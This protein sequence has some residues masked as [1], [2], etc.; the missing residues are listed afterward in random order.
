MTGKVT[1]YQSQ[2]KHRVRSRQPSYIK[3][4]SS[5]GKRWLKEAMKDDAFRMGMG[6]DVQPSEESLKWNW[7][8]NAKTPREWKT[9]LGG[10]GKPVKDFT[11]QYLGVCY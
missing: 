9:G 7:R 8:A 10:W 5:R 11:N 3:F 2:W 6:A 4:T 1:G